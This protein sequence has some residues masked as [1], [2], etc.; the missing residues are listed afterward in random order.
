MQTIWFPT[1]VSV[2]FRRLVNVVSSLSI[3]HQYFVHKHET[4]DS[5]TSGTTVK[6]FAWFPWSRQTTFALAMEGDSESSEL[7]AQ[8]S[9]PQHPRPTRNRPLDAIHRLIQ[10]PTLYDPIRAPRNPIVLCHGEWLH[11]L[12]VF[13]VYSAIG[14]Y[15]F[16][17]RGPEFFPMLRQHYWSNVLTILR[18]KVGAEVVVTS[19]PSTGS[20]ASRARTLH[21]LLKER[22][23]GRSINFMAHSMGGLDCRHLISHIK[24]TEYTPLSLTT[25][26]TPHRGSPFMDWCTVSSRRR[27]YIILC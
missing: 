4:N 15:G 18:E 2:L 27:I 1:P 22:V 12:E 3:S 6:S 26:A 16:D 24:P 25:V 5:S 23:L 14:L 11:I 10:Y 17:V 21:G 20:I 7:N 19:V 13:A 8:Q 9:P